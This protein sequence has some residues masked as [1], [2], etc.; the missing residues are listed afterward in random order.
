MRVS[1]SFCVHVFHT[2]QWL[3]AEAPGQHTAAAYCL[4]EPTQDRQ[5]GG[6]GRY[7]QH[8]GIPNSRGNERLVQEIAHGL[9]VSCF[10]STGLL[11]E[12][13][14]PN[15]QMYLA[16]PPHW[17]FIA[18]QSLRFAGIALKL[19][20]TPYAASIPVARSK[21]QDLCARRVQVGHR[22]ILVTKAE[23]QHLWRQ[24][25]TGGARQQL[26][27]SVV[28]ALGSAVGALEVVETVEGEARCVKQELCT[29][30][31]GHIGGLGLGLGLACSDGAGGR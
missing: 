19:L 13:S 9:C 18:D 16:P 12:K 22:M 11:H 21:S 20:V 15:E 25:P 29:V 26:L 2:K 10:T 3:T 24:N 5:K 14:K 31:T 23:L 17:P 30:Q 1:A 28:A 4:S 27:G 8:L 6:M 7:S